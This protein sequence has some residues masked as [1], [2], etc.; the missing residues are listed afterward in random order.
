MKAVAGV[1]GT[2]AHRKCSCY[3][4]DDVMPFSHH[5][6][7][8]VLP[9]LLQHF[10]CFRADINLMHNNFYIFLVFSSTVSKGLLGEPP[11]VCCL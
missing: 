2:H 5:F 4:N 9:S 11:S 1:A 3:S 6:R 7:T 8:C 10:W